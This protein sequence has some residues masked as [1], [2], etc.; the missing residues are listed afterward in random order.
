MREQQANKAETRDKMVVDVLQQMK[1]SATDSI[2]QMKTIVSESTARLERVMRMK[3]LVD[4]DW[5]HMS[6]AFRDIAKK[7]IEE[8]FTETITGKRDTNTNE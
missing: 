5:S 7:S 4:S 6:D 1:Q 8:Y 3:L 2:Q